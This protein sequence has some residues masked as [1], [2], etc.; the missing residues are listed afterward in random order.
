MTLA[1]EAI[2]STSLSWLDDVDDD[3]DDDDELFDILL[4]SWIEFFIFRSSQILFSVWDRFLF[5]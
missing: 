4:F 5:A 2:T 3:D 1:A